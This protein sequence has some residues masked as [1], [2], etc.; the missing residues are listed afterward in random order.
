MTREEVI[1]TIKKHDNIVEVWWTTGKHFN[2]D[3]YDVG[4]FV[5]KSNKGDWTSH[6]RYSG[7]N[8]THCPDWIEPE[9]WMLDSIPNEEHDY[10]V[11]FGCK[12]CGLTSHSE[13]ECNRNLD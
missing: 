11:S 8:W 9:Q 7:V 12:N 5:T 2:D 10:R 1:N 6:P 13:D 3:Q 4:M